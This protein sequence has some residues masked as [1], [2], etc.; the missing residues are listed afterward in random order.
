VSAFDFEVSTSGAATEVFEDVPARFLVDP[1]VHGGRSVQVRARAHTPPG[2]SWSARVSFTVATPVPSL[3][4][5]ADNRH[6]TATLPQVVSFVF[7][8]K[9]AGMADA[10]FADTTSPFAIDAAVY[11]GRTV[12]VSAASAEPPGRPGRRRSS[13]RFRR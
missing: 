11:G 13:S 5:A 10:Y 6:V 1:L 12:T 2:S 9:S 7:V 8:V 4:R 3:V